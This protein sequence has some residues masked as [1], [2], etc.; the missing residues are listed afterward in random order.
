MNVFSQNNSKEKDLIMKLFH[1]FVKNLINTIL[2]FIPI[3]GIII[4]GVLN[5]TDNIALILIY[6]AGCLIFFLLSYNYIILNIKIIVDLINKETKS[7]EYEVEGVASAWKWFTPFVKRKYITD[8]FCFNY[9]CVYDIFLNENEKYIKTTLFMSKK[10]LE[11]TNFYK[12]YQFN[13]TVAK[14]EIIYQKNINDTIYVECSFFKCS[15]IIKE[16]KIYKK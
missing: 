16:F 13:Y 6:I 10:E 1:I 15:G 3:V 5:K 12:F 11:K 7:V 8:I 14:E 2:Y 4:F 9:T